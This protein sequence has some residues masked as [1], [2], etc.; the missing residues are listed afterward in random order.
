LPDDKDDKEPKRVMVINP[1]SKYRIR[2][3]DAL[4]VIAESE[5]TKL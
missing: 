3:G 5:P 1:Q 4:F 2:Q